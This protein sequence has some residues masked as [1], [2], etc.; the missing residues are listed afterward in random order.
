MSWIAQK[1]GSAWQMGRNDCMT[2]LF[3]YL[4]HLNNSDRLS[5]I[6]NKYNSKHSAVRFW[7]NMRTTT[8]QQMHLMGY[9]KTVDTPREMDIAITETIYPGAYYRHNDYWHGIEEDGYFGAFRRLPQEA[10]VW[11]RRRG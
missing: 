9:A 8:G 5:E 3:E 6:K 10:V 11:R 7:R 1:H 4:D 2:C